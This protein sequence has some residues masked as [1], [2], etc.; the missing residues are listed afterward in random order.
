VSEERPFIA[1]LSWRSLRVFGPDAATWLNG[2]VTCD[3]LSSSE[4]RVIWGSLL[5]KQGKV[6]GDLQ[7]TGAQDDLLVGV[8]GGLAD[9]ILETL[10][11]YLVMEDAEIEASEECWALVCGEEAKQAA[12][13]AGVKTAEPNWNVPQL[14][15]ARGEVSA[16]E[17]LQAGEPEMAAARQKASAWLTKHGIPQFGLDYSAQDNLHAASLERRTVDWSKGCYLGQE[18]VCMQDMRGKVKKRLVQLRAEA[19]QNLAAAQE[20]VTAESGESVGKL[21]S[22]A[23]NVGVG[24]VIAP[25]FEPGAKLKVGEI[26]VQVAP[27]LEG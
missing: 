13:A 12:R 22:A 10:D 3:V 14:F 2:I 16:L 20:L 23:G 25:H 15:L 8:S 19:G 5:T 18:V 27:L 21:T 24:T 17:A 1:A 7:I 11:G 26:P 9:E 6:Q 4:D